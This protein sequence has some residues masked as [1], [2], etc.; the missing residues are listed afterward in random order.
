MIGSGAHVELLHSCPEQALAP[1][2]YGAELAH[3]PRTHVRIA[4]Q[5]ASGESLPLPLARGLHAF[6]DRDRALPSSVISQLLVVHAGTSMWISKRSGS[7]PEDAGDS[8]I[9]PWVAADHRG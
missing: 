7:G 3:F 9:G 6:S 4:R 1:L 2:V 5:V 8:H